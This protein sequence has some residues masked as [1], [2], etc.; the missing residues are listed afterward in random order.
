MIKLREFKI[1]L[2]ELKEKK[3]EEAFLNA[4]DFNCLTLF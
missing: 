4:C 2:M 1:Y 3:A